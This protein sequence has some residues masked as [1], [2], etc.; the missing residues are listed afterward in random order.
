MKRLE[1]CSLLH[2]TPLA[3][4]FN[5]KRAHLTNSRPCNLP[6][7]SSQPQRESEVLPGPPRGWCGP[8]TEHLRSGT[9]QWEPSVGYL[10]GIWQPVGR[11]SGREDY[12]IQV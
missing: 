2:T 6:S 4:V 1:K 11:G 3:S 10:S 12:L 8:Q 5:S 7:S 9:A